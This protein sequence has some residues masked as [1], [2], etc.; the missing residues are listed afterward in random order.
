MGENQI[1]LGRLFVQELIRAGTWG[2][3]LLFILGIFMLSI[4]QEIKEGIAYGVERVASEAVMVGTNPY[5][6]GKSKQLIKEGIE[7]TL[8]KTSREIRG[9]LNEYSVEMEIERKK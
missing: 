5:L 3:V 6:I 2:I 1:S 7:Y 9:I 4:K 8:A